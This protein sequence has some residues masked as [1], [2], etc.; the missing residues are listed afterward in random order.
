MTKLPEKDLLSGS[1]NTPRTTTGEIGVLHL[2]RLRDL[3]SE[4]FGDDAVATRKPARQCARAS[5]PADTGKPDGDGNRL[6]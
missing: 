5:R 1:R 6:V 4:L 3:L 2:G